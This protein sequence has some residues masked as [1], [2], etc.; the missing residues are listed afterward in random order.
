[1]T[2]EYA[3]KDDDLHELYITKR[4]DEYSTQ[5]RTEFAW[6]IALFKLARSNKEVQRAERA[7]RNAL[8]HLRS[9]LDW[10]EDTN[11]EDDAHAQLDKAGTFI[12][13]TFGCNFLFEEGTYF[14]TCP[15]ALG[16]NR[17]GFSIGATATRICSLCG[18]DLSECEHLKGNAYFV[19][20]GYEDLGHCRVCLSTTKCDHLPD[21][22]Y[23]ASVCAKLIEIELHEVSLVN[24]PAHPE[25]R[26]QKVSISSEK[27]RQQLGEEFV[28]GMPVSCDYCLSEC[29][30]LFRPNDS[31][32]NSISN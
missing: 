21:K 11:K 4:I 26:I 30:G 29:D 18:E 25:A 1:M 12:R 20:G 8:K 19:P 16:H 32:L 27:I 5:G 23:R 7:G 3:G 9:A 15:V 6:S 13:K 22:I 24:R 10:A 31:T 28:D 17:I 2:F 14:Q